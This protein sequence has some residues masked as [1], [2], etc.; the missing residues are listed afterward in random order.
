MGTKHQRFKIDRDFMRALRGTGEYQAFQDSELR[1]FGVKVTPTGSASYT[2]RWTKPDGTQGRRTVGYW[3]ATNP[4]DAREAAK[5]ESEIIDRKGDT[6]T[7][8]A[9]RRAKRTE[10]AKSALGVPTL[11]R[12]LE[13]SYTAVLRTYCKTADHGDANARI[14]VQ[15]FPDLLDDVL[16]TIT[17]DRLERCR[18]D[19]LAR[20]LAKATT[21]KKL[22]ALQG[23]LTH[24][25]DCEILSTHPMQKIGML[26]EPSGVVRYLTHE[27]A[28]RFYAAM[29]A[30]EN[31]L[32]A[33]RDRANDHRRRRGYPLM[34]CL[35]DAE[36]V[37]ALRPAVL[38]SLMTGLRKSEL[39]NL[40]WTDIDL[41]NRIVTVRDEHAKS[42]KLRRIPMNAALYD[43]FITWKPLV[44]PDSEYVFA[45]ESGEPIQC[46]KKS[47]AAVLK[48]AR[49][50]SFRWHDMRHTF[51]SW[52]V[53]SGVD[54]NI[55]R[56]LMGHATL[57]MTM[58]YAHLAPNNSLRAV[59]ALNLTGPNIVQN[60]PAPRL[61]A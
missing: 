46:M 58:R 56:E 54:L 3:P 57:Q 47:F 41:M 49:I 6:L 12:F 9:V 44:H 21:N 28:K 20:G 53:Q 39:F 42:G 43:V 7:V 33:A 18:A 26:P 29:I 32:R 11:R 10:I 17:A 31:D 13:D 34:P 1:G 23:L 55:V 52:L 50:E 30:R 51:A 5:R 59:S 48:A 15:S 37:D 40:R 27:E 24:A 45:G 4:G 36:F 22:T 60:A 14:I 8:T 16:D 35:H 25:V 38:V 61:A 2:Y 19:M